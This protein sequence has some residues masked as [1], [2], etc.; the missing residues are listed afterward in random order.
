MKTYC[1]I[2][3]V[4]A[5]TLF[6]APVQTTRAE[7]ATDTGAGSVVRQPIADLAEAKRAQKALDEFI[8]AYETGN[9]NLIRS[10]IDPA[11]IGYQR[12]ID[13]VIRDFN[14]LKQIRIHLSDT[15]V[16]AGPDVAVIQTSW[17]KRFLSVT[18][19]QPGLFS[20]RSIFLLHRDKEAWRLAAFAGD[21]VFSSQSGVLAKITFKPSVIAFSTIPGAPG[22]VA[23]QTEVVDPDLSGR[24]NLN[25]EVVTGQGDREII[26]LNTITPG[27]FVR[28]SL[29]MMQDPIIT[30][31]SGVIEVA[32]GQLPTSM[33][34]RYMDNNPGRNRPP[35]RLSKSIKIQ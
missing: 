23:V 8:R 15:Q 17:E 2:I 32:P 4:A 25:V 9:I 31:G 34:L 29:T 35:S 26:T 1:I 19:F 11:M 6:S 30:Q 10:R 28:N 3:L 21:N 27:R 20:G 13:G 7:N 12:F 33:T 14:A 16:L 18:D 5:L 24:S 22:P